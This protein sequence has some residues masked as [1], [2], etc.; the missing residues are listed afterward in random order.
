M[1]AAGVDADGGTA[2]APSL[3]PAL[4]DYK[5]GPGESGHMSEIRC[6]LVE[7]DV[8]HK[9]LVTLVYAT[10]DGERHVTRQRSTAMLRQ[11]PPT[12][13]TDVP[14]SDLE[15]VSDP[16]DRERYSKEADRIAERRDP[17]EQV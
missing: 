17:D 5:D 9:N 1:T 13:A 14:E 15:P 3:A 4:A 11:D 10:R 2:P 8:G 6:W 16:D 12:A 7:R